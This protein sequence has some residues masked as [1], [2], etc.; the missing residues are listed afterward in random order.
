ML[1]KNNLVSRYFADFALFSSPDSELSEAVNKWERDEK[2]IAQ[3]YVDG[4]NE[5]LLEVE[6]DPASLLPFEFVALGFTP[7]LWTVNQMLAWS[8]IM[9][10][11]SDSEAFDISQIKNAEM[12]TR[13]SRVYGNE[14]AWAMFDDLR[15]TQDPAAITSIDHGVS[16]N[17]RR[18]MSLEHMNS[19]STRRTETIDNP[20]KIEMLAIEMTNT[21]KNVFDALDRIKAIVKLGSYGWVLS[22]DY[23]ESRNPT[24]YAGSQLGLEAPSRAAEGSIQAGGLHVS[25][26]VIPGIPMIIDTVRSPHNTW[27]IEVASAHTTDYFLEDANEVSLHRVETIVVAGQDDVELPI[28]RG[29]GPVV[30]ELG[31][32]FLTW[33]YSHWNY[34]LRTLGGFLKMVRA[35]NMDE[36]EVGVTELGLSVHVLYADRDGN[37]AY[38]MAGRDPVRSSGEWR[39]PQGFLNDPIDWD[40]AVIKPYPTDRNTPRGWY[41]NWNNKPNVNYPTGFNAVFKIQGPFHGVHAIYDY[42]NE[43][44]DLNERLTFNQIRD[45]ALNI[46]VTES[47]GTRLGAAGTPWIFVEKNTFKTL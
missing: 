35:T 36:F 28:Y 8:V 37:I 42:L 20:S 46:A 30:E 27:A 39:L 1:L 15:W 22:G 14:T 44:L 7:E 24:L 19:P 21:L 40:A 47:L 4:I 5:R 33:K 31:D 16:G 26:E 32:K 45:L 9:Q 11:D 25:G 17:L 41:G 3:G 6:A 38:W 34:E 43:K 12:I 29:R 2:D 23:T 13:L 10:R 18:K